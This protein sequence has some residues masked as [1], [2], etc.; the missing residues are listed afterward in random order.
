MA[1]ELTVHDFIEIAVK[2]AA[3]FQEQKDYLNQLDMTIGDGDH[4]LSMA[5]G[6]KAVYEYATTS[7]F[8]NI[9]DFLIK[10]A[11]YFNEAAGSTIGLLLYSAMSEAGKMAAGETV[12]G[13]SQL[14]DLLE[15]AINGIRSRGK[16]ER[17]AK[18]ILDSLYPALDALRQ[19]LKETPA[20]E[21]D[22]LDRVLTAAKEGAEST[23]SMKSVIG[24]S[25]WFPERSIGAIDPGSVSGM[26]ILKTIIEHIKDVMGKTH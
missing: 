6:F 21:A 9:S 15:A 24:R 16:A 19:G 3:T 20:R 25:R 4:G 5:R 12:V 26:L 13:L 18:T 1:A 10:G 23:A 2:L 22:I 14:A 17:G 8:R 11:R 7:D